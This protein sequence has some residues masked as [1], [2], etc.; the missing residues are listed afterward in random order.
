MPKRPGREVGWSRTPLALLNLI[1]PSCFQRIINSLGS[2][3]PAPQDLGDA[4][5]LRDAAARR[6]GLDGVEDFADGADAG[7]VQVRREAFQELARARAV[8]GVGLEPSVYEG[9]D[10][11][12]PDRALMVGGVARLEVAVVG[13]LE[14]GVVGRERAEADGRQELFARDV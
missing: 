13:R 8:F 6:V 12:S 5:S 1:R 2:E 11:P 9:A 4:P 3:N 14:V 10:E 7:L